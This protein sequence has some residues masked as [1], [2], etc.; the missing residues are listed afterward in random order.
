M[1]S[2]PPSSYELIRTLDKENPQCQPRMN[3]SERQIFY[4]AGQRDL[5]DY[6]LGLIEEEGAD[7]SNSKT[8]VQLG[9]ID[10]G[11]IL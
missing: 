7:K 1:D 6:L 8:S 2:L 9:G 4:N 11:R 5:I 10:D 3:E